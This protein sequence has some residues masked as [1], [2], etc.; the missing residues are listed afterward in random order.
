MIFL[1]EVW[2]YCVYRICFKWG[3][4]NI[5]S[6]KFKIVCVGIEN[7]VFVFGGKV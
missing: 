7:D 3:Y 5:E 1:K 6:K 4:E 2:G